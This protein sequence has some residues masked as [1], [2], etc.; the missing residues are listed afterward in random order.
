MSSEHKLYVGLATA[1]KQPPVAVGLLKMLRRGNIESGEYAYGKQYLASPSAI[2]LNHDYLPLTSGILPLPGQRLRDGGVLPLTFKD[3][4]PDSWGRRVLE[5]QHGGPLDD[6]DVLLMTNEDRVGALVFSEALPISLEHDEAAL[7]SLEALADSVR[8]LELG[9]EVPPQMR[10]LL[11][12]G[13]TLGGARPKATFIHD[14]RRWIA[15]FPSAAD[16]H[17]VE[18]LEIGLLKLASMCGIE[19]SPA[20]LVPIPH[21]HAIL[22]QRFDR[23][24]AIGQESRQ[25]YLSAAALL[26]VSYETGLGSYEEFAQ[27]IRRLS[28][29]PR[30]DLHQLY[31]RMIFNLVVDNT[32][33]H[34]KNHG[35]LHVGHG[36]YRLAPAFDIEMQ[37]RNLGYQELAITPGQQHSSIRLALEV[38]PA[39]GINQQDAATIIQEIE[40]TVQQHL[41]SI[42]ASF[43]AT[44]EFQS[45]IGQ[46]LKRQ[47][48][49]IHG[50]V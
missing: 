32:D 21:G 10:R 44:P 7:V 47:R 27:V 43:G 16:T 35:M 25:H 26:N 37:L 24:G 30:E 5:A 31:R 14:Q 2:A 41:T 38:S 49:I 33:D 48:E 4:L 20:H 28:I 29:N 17:D 23:H 39:F 1:A 42:A 45:T 15:K 36:Q 13:G 12:R 18:L 6:L 3:A 8:S 34:V 46:C 22:I 19:V 9:M 50:V 11:H 40:T